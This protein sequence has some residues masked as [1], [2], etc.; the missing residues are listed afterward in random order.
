MKRK[1]ILLQE[2]KLSMYKPENEYSFVKIN[3]YSYYLY[4]SSGDMS[5]QNTLYCKYLITPEKY[6]FDNSQ[7][8]YII[9]EKIYLE[10]NK[11]YYIGKPFKVDLVYGIQYCYLHLD[12]LICEN[13]I[14]SRKKADLSNGLIGYTEQ[15]A[16]KLTVKEYEEIKNHYKIRNIKN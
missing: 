5:I 9:S 6:G 7:I 1:R 14:Y 15:K 10:Y 13:T 3:S 16:I 2:I 11:I 12:N 8:R 4:I